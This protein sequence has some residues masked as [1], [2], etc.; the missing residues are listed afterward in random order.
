MFDKD[1]GSQGPPF[2][3]C[4]QQE[5]YGFSQQFLE[6]VFVRCCLTPA[7]QCISYGVD[8]R[9]GLLMKSPLAISEQ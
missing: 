9:M 1:G 7:R 3:L 8:F 5:R 6:P 4:G 2:F